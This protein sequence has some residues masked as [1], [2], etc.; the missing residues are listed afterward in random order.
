M[1]HLAAL[2]VGDDA[3]DTDEGY[4]GQGQFLFAMLGTQGNH[5]T[6]MDSKTN[7]V[8]DS[9]PRSHPA[10]Y[11][12]TIIGGGSESTRSSNALMRLRE[13]TGGKFINLLLDNPTNIGVEIR[14]CAASTW[15]SA[16]QITQ[17]TSFISVP[18][19]LNN[20]LYFSSQNIITGVP[21]SG[22]LFSIDTSSCPSTL[23]GFTAVQTDPLLMSAHNLWSRFELDGGLSAT[24]PLDP[25]PVCGGAAF[26][27]VEDVAASALADSFYDSVSFKVRTGWPFQSCVPAF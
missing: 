14:Q 7:G 27:D 24:L 19:N 21:S 12:M 22:S 17:D 18:S 6:E 15:A 5:G 2:F 16:Y 26:S 1:K 13:G 11:S 23:L 3:F 20:Y 8:T 25:R 4:Q 10:F 9:L